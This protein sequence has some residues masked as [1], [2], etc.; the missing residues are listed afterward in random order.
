[1]LKVL[2]EIIPKSIKIQIIEHRSAIK[3]LKVYIPG[4]YAFLYKVCLLC[5][6]VF[7]ENPVL[8]YKKVSSIERQNNTNAVY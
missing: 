4:W 7:W 3:S 8:L 6:T 2:S 1:M 5:A